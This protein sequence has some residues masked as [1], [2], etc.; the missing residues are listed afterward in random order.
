[1]GKILE[2]VT[3]DG[4]QYPHYR[5]MTPEE[6][7]EIVEIPDTRS[8]EEKIVDKIREK[9]SINDE[10]AILRQRDSKP[11]EFIEYNSFVEQIKKEIK[12]NQ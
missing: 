10:I 9:Y 6:E 4:V 2:F 11:E 8:Y 12:R 5:D 1:M 7:S 3:I